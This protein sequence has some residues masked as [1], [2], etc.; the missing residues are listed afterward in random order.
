MWSKIVNAPNLRSKDLDTLAERLESARIVVS[1]I[2]GG[3]NVS[4]DCEPLFC[5]DAPTVE[6]IKR[7]VEETLMSYIVNFYQVENVVVKA[8]S[9]P[10][11]ELKIPV[12]NVEP[13][14]FIRPS[15]TKMFANRA[16]LA[17]V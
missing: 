9:F 4:S 1:E 16:D 2:D 17:I 15:L 11:S 8:E 3:F 5:F 13:V 7:L 12:R 6:G 10:T 14:S